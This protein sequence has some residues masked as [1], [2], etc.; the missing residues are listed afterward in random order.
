MR[1]EPPSGPNKILARR[2]S[3]RRALILGGLTAAGLAALFLSSRARL[4]EGRANLIARIA[5]Y[6]KQGESS[7]QHR[8]G[9]EPG[10]AAE[11]YAALAYLLDPVLADEPP[12]R[13]EGIDFL[14][15]RSLASRP[16]TITLRDRLRRRAPPT[17]SPDEAASLAAYRP[18]VEFIRR[19]A[20]RRACRWRYPFEKGLLAENWMLTPLTA[21]G[22][23]MA[24]ESYA[25]RSPDEAAIRALEM[26]I[27]GRDFYRHPDHARAVA[28]LRLLN[29][30]FLALEA[31]LER[32]VSEG[33]LRRILTVL[34]A[35]PP[36]D[37]ARRIEADDLAMGAQ[38]CA[39][40]GIAL[41]RSLEPEA[42]YDLIFPARKDAWKRPLLMSPLG[43]NRA[44]GDHRAR[45][46][47]ARA[48][49]E[50]PAR[51]RPVAWSRLRARDRESE[52]WVYSVHITSSLSPL[53]QS[54]FFA[55]QQMQIIVAAARLY[56]SKHG[57]FPSELPELAAILKA[58]PA[59]PYRD[60]G[61]PFQFVN[62]GE[63]IT[64]RSAFPGLE[65]TGRPP[66]PR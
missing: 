57:A 26:Q 34:E 49:L 3:R 56:H 53:Y 59:D 8:L 51:R 48:I 27:I 25:A 13:P 29:N 37:S 35:L 30:A 55:R 28:G 19:A 23:M 58:I 41:D 63:S 40:A 47:A 15:I 62:D 5:A 17:P 36:L 64:I 32:P 38:L 21:L 52:P 10:D 9:D 31:A 12:P 61:G 2:R 39:I 66:Q 18:L 60:G 14:R 54:R 45:C 46:N 16:D 24:F 44:W 42:S 50:L 22:N 1:P 65:L 20:Y 7:P 43:I 4:R 6:R 33:A 11:V